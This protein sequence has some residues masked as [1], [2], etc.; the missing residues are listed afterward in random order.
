VSLESVGFGETVWER[1]SGNIDERSCGNIYK[2]NAGNTSE[3]R[4]GGRC[5]VK[6]EIV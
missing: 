2:R 4:L 1:C 6:E 3:W 5:L